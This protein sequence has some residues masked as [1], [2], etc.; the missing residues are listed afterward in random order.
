VKHQVDE[1]ASWQISKLA[2]SKL[3]KHQINETASLQN[4]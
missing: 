2:K 3:V 1:T 4:S